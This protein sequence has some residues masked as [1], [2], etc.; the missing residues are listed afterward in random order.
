M[1][2]F[3]DNLEICPHGRV[4]GLDSVCSECKRE[5]AAGVAGQPAEAAL[6]RLMNILYGPDLDPEYA[7]DVGM[8]DDIANVLEE[9]FCRCGV[10]GCY[11]RMPA[12]PM[13]P[14]CCAKCVDP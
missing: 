3:N 1:N 12:Q 14:V 4:V 8:L 9:L 13:A 5:A 6:L 11:V 2:A 10:C 7:F